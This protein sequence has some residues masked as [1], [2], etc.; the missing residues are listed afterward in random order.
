MRQDRLD[1][2][3]ENEVPSGLRVEQRRDPE[4]IARGE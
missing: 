2:G 3:S 4:M 1:L